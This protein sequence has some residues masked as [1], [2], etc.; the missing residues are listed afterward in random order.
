MLKGHVFNLQTFTSEAF[1]ITFDKVLH[2]KCGVL[3][4][5]KLSNTSN[6]ATIGDGY[7]VVRG[8]ILQVIGN[9]TVS[10]IIENGFYSLVC[11]VDLSKTNTKD[12]FVQAETKIVQNSNDYSNLIQQDITDTGTIYQ[13]E[14]ARFKV[15]NGNITN[16]TDERTFIDFESIYDSI[17]GQTDEIINKIEQALKNVLDGS[18]YL[19]KTGGTIDG[20]L[21]VTG[22]ITGTARK[23]RKIRKQKCK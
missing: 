1:A 11:E 21:E 23:F 20:N 2:G 9:E 3:N 22:N 13:Y 16:F 4:G 18:A 5:C 17:Q 6:S 14:F 12:L 10:N 8:R 7:F 19:L 15:E